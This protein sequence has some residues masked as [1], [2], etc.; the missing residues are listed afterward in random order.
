[1]NPKSQPLLLLSSEPI[2]T[3]AVLVS[4]NKSI[5]TCSRSMGCVQIRLTD[6]F[7][8]KIIISSQIHLICTNK[9][10]SKS[11]VLWGSDKINLWF[12]GQRIPQS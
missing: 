1:M 5:Q 4:S 9:T 3:F 2:F 10:E 6:I 8:K 11:K 12:L 7:Y